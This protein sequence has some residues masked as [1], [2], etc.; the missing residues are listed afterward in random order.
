MI[1]SQHSILQSAS[2]ARLKE[3]HYFNTGPVFDAG[4][5][6]FSPFFS[7]KIKKRVSYYITF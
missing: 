1:T 2:T 6:L 3:L 5:A 7:S 4:F